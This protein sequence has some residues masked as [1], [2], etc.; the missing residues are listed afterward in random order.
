VTVIFLIEAFF[1]IVAMGFGFQR[2]TYIRDPWNILDFLI[3]ISGI[4]DFFG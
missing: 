3:C 1:K 2:Y 4:S